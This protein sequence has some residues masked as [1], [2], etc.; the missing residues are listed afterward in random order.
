MDS[1]IDGNCK[2]RSK[3]CIIL[4]WTSNLQQFSRSLSWE[5]FTTIRKG[6]ISKSRSLASHGSIGTAIGSLVLRS[7]TFK[8]HGEHCRG[9]SKQ[10]NSGV[11]TSRRESSVMWWVSTSKKVKDVNKEW[12]R[13]VMSWCHQTQFYHVLPPYLTT[14]PLGA[15]TLIEIL[16]MN[17]PW[18]MFWHIVCHICHDPFQHK[19]PISFFFEVLLRKHTLSH[20]CDA[21]DE[22][23]KDVVVVRLRH[24]LQKWQLSNVQNCDL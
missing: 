1:W 18:P 9:S 16:Y 23:H 20:L 4:F 17:F 8:W 3:F 10:R 2:F 14:Y 24:I 5:L 6:M 15:Q 22:T 21:I 7:L 19:S 11:C 12:T 13:I